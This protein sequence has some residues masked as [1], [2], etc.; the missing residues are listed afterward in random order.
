MVA[1]DAQDVWTRRRDRGEAP[2]GE[3]GPNQRQ[4]DT[5]SRQFVSICNPRTSMAAT[6][7]AGWSCGVGLLD[8]QRERGK[9]E[10]GTYNNRTHPTF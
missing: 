1:T 6:G 10:D 4:W 2:G 7:R 3:E 9:D 8:R 5:Q